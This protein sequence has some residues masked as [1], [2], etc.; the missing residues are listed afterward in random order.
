LRGYINQTTHELTAWG[1]ALQS[2]L[3]SVTEYEEIEEAILLAFELIREGVIKI[4]QLPSPPEKQ[5][6]DAPSKFP[7]NHSITR[8]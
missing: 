1:K 5:V 2:A 7:P 3:A 8:Y 6:E 4:D